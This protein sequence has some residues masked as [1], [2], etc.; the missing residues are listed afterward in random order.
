MNRGEGGGTRCAHPR[1]T[2]F[3]PSRHP[4]GGMRSGRGKDGNTEA[5]LPHHLQLCRLLWMVLY[6]ATDAL[7]RSGR[8]GM[9]AAVDRPLRLMQT[10]AALEISRGLVELVRFPVSA[11]L[12]QIGSR[13]FVT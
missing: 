5:R 11:T 4:A 13:L 6:Y 2:S 8:E 1:V 7:L 3:V 9:H 10:V 12:P